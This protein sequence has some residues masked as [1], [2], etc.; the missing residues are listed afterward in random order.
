MRNRA[1]N[2]E[3]IGFLGADERPLP[4]SPAPKKETIRWIGAGKRASMCDPGPCMR[5]T[6][7][8]Q[9]QK[10]CPPPPPP[11]DESGRCPAGTVPETRCVP[12]RT[13]RTTRIVEKCD[14]DGNCET[15]T[16]TTTTTIPQIPDGGG[17][18][19]EVP[20]QPDGGG[21]EGPVRPGEPTS[22]T[23]PAE[24]SEEPFEPL[25]DYT[26]SLYSAIPRSALRVAGGGSGGGS[27]SRRVVRRRART[28]TEDGG[29][30]FPGPDG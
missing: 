27:G 29:V 6:D 18:G 3:A 11:L 4:P 10:E 8:E 13:T 17:G 12:G 24:P 30:L 16:T 28:T 9:E 26:P 14:A 5:E 1:D 25:L 15:E 23:V 21:F 22:F 2:D 20:V 7:Q 19:F